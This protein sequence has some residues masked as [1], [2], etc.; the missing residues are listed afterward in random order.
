MHPFR[1]ADFVSPHPEESTAYIVLLM[2]RMAE[3][4]RELDRSQDAEEFSRCAGAAR[5]GYQALVRTQTH[6][7]P[8]SSRCTA[9][10]VPQTVPDGA[11]EKDARPS[12]SSTRP[13]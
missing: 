2:E 13:R 6:S 10:V 7:L 12:G 8:S 3:I 4:A 11:S 9:A 1:T 5:E